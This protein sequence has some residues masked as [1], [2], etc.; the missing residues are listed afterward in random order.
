MESSLCGKEFSLNHS[1]LIVQIKHFHQLKKHFNSSASAGKELRKHLNVWSHSIIY[2]HSP[3]RHWTIQRDFKV[4]LC[5]KVIWGE[6][7]EEKMIQGLACSSHEAQERRWS[8]LRGDILKLMQ[9]KSSWNHLAQDK[10][11]HL[12]ANFTISFF[13]TVK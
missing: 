7:A 12:L 13:F 3:T 11:F 4:F 10:L 2:F 5:L 1:W 6:T 9:E 8:S